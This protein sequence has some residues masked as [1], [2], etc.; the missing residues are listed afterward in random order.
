VKVLTLKSHRFRQE[1]E[2]DWKRL[3]A[4]LRRAERG[5]A[6]RLSD[7]EILALPVLYRTALSSLSVARAI[8]L[9]QSLI[10][11]LESL[12]TRAYFFV[13]GPRTKLIHRIARFFGHDWPASVRA[14]WRETLVAT[15][16]S[17]L[18]VIAAY[19][20][21]LDDAS[22]FYS[23]VPGGLAGGRDPSASAD[24]LRES[25]GGAEDASGLT[26]FSTYLFTHNSQVALL[27]F[28]LGFALCLPT[29][30]LL[31]YNG[32]TVGA[33]V[34]V[35]AAAGL[36]YEVGGWLLI[37]GV[38]EIF[39]VILAGAAGLRIGWTLAFPGEKARADALAVAGRTSAIVMAGVVVML[40]FAGLLEG[41]GR[42]L[43]VVTELRYA[44]ALA[45]GLWWAL[46]FYLPR[47]A[48][49]ERG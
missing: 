11:Y 37:H 17:V 32:M 31:L 19:F 40:G 42:Q 1:R 3:E 15:G 36:R 21:V 33:F 5:S 24:F 10:E 25:L 4:L 14:L 7:E 12:C 6:S 8:S 30:L 23:F 45:T 44:V 47:Q 22:W 26:V 46:Y 20:L 2:A 41:F 28:A 35:F 18:G 29:V 9:D 48:V 13:Y 49:D 34:A 39:A 43:I 16:L 27:A 38:T